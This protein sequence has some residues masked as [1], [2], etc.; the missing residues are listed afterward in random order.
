M[1]IHSQVDHDVQALKRKLPL[2]RRLMNL[3]ILAGVVALAVRYVDFTQVWKLIISADWRY[4][5]LVLALAT[6][7][8]FLMAW[9]WH[10][11]LLAAEVPAAFVGALGAYYR[12]SMVSQVPFMVIGAD[13]LRMHWIGSRLGKRAVVAATVVMEKALGLISA[14]FLGTLG[15]SLILAAHRAGDQSATLMVVGLFGLVASLLLLGLSLLE[16][17]HL[18]MLRVVSR[19]APERLASILE[20]LSGAY[21][22]V[23]GKR[24][25]ILRV[26]ILTILEHIVQFLMLYFSGRAIGVE[27]EM[28]LFLAGISVAAMVRRVAIYVEGWGLAQ[29]A[30]VLVFTIVGLTV[31]QSLSLSL[32]TDAI[33]IVASLPG[34]VLLVRDAV[35][36]SEASPVETSSG[37]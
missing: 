1:K 9:K 12:S 5:L 35:A 31:E 26:Q 22:L 4:V 37:L 20:R 32:L 30:S 15:L 18:R 19:L 24:W 33:T 10:R 23:G 6:T 21:R 11:L 16:G 36:S 17:L 29:A 27:L 14:F 7:S 13:L 34:L 25:T 3:A 8:R 28:P 2:W